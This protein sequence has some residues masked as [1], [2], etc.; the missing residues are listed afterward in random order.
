MSDRPTLFVI[1][2]G[3][4]PIAHL[5]LESHKLIQRIR[6]VAFVGFEPQVAEYLRMMNCDMV[7]LR[8]LYREG[9]ARPTVYREISDVVLRMAASAGAWVFLA[10][11][12]PC[13]LNTVVDHLRSD[14]PARG[15]QV[16]VYSGVS[17][18]DTIITELNIP[19]GR[20]GL[21]CFEATQ[22]VRMRPRIDVR[23][24]LLL[25]QPNVVV[26]DTIRR[27]AGASIGGVEILRDCLLDY[28]APTQSWILAGSPMDGTAIGTYRA[29]RLDGLTESAHWMAFGSLLIPGETELQCPSNGVDPG[30]ETN[31]KLESGLPL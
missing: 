16:S 4:N 5:T 6:K 23:V 1:G 29:G 3:I 24:P 13:F 26:D 11:G 27:N 10:P 18:V 12:N 25:F 8:D 30:L 7:D 31:S 17:C 19:V 15:I 2:Y 20:S 9:Q 22:F 14:G 28:Y 21:Q